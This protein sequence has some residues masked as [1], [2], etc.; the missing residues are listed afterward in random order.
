MSIFDRIRHAITGYRFKREF[1]SYDKE[2]ARLR[3]QHKR[4][5]L[6]ATAAKRRAVNM[7]LAGKTWVKLP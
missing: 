7:A 5:V 4:G 3:K 2:I 1:A 6:E